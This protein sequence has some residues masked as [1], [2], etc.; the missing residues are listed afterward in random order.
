[1]S[2]TLDRRQHELQ[3]I[4]FTTYLYVAA[5]VSQMVEP[6]T[7]IIHAASVHSGNLIANVYLF[8]IFIYISLAH[9]G[10]LSS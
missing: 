4:F 8:I 3:R 1:M 5:R 9:D 10:I 7:L 6:Q 2:H